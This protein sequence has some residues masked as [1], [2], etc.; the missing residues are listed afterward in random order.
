[1]GKRVT[2]VSTAAEIRAYAA[3]HPNAAQ[4]AIASAIGCSRQAVH[5][6][7]RAT[8][9]RGRPTEDGRSP[10]TVRLA[11]RL[12]DIARVEAE[13]DGITLQDVLERAIATRLLA[14]RRR[15][16]RAEAG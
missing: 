4:S 15:A 7:L 6:A 10:V 14:P 2:R 12:L 13:R 9:R 11:P 5:N 3:A 16:R 1:M 8:G